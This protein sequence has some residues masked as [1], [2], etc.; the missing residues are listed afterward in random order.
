MEKQDRL[1]YRL[2]IMALVVIFASSC[3]NDNSVPVLLTSEV[4]DITH[5]TA[6]CGGSITS[7]GGATVTACGVCWSTNQTPTISDSKTI[8]GTGSGSFT[9]T[10]T[11]LTENTTYYVRAYA[12]NRYGTGYGSVMSFTTQGI[13]SY[14]SFT[15]S[16]DGKVYQTVIIDN[17]E[18]MAEN[19]AYLPSVVGATT[20]S[21]TT[22]CCYVY[23]YNGTDVSEAKATTNYTTFGVLYNW[24][25]AKEAVPPGWHLPSDSEWTS[26]EN[27]LIANGFNYDGTTTENKIAKSLA[28]TIGWEISTNVGSVGNTDYPEYRNK[29]GFSALPGGYHFTNGHFRDIGI[30]GYWWSSSEY[31]TY[32]AWYHYMHYDY[33]GLLRDEGGQDLGLSVRCVRD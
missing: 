27:F 31:E 23:G 21:L 28:S 3:E 7:D 15:D 22:P 9:S 18:W 29:S 5:T 17:K 10:I 13:I 33:M 2:L 19:L 14:S 30:S 8:I 6:L 24:E 25:A 32:F 1:L 11:G 26:L 12:I 4:T 16:R 20:G